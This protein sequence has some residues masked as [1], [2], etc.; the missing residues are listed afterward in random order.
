MRASRSVCRAR[1]LAAAASSRSKP[2]GLARAGGL[3]LEAHEA[4]ARDLDLVLE[5]AEPRAGEGRVHAQQHVALAHPVAVT[6]Q[7]LGDDAALEVL[8]ELA[9]AVGDH[10]ARRD[11]RGIEPREDRP[12]EEAAEGD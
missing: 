10:H 4:R 6:Y 12:A 9:V 8:H 1:S 3:G 11:R 7:Q 5:L 2:A